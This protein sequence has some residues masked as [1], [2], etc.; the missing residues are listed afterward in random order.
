MNYINGDFCATRPDFSSINPSTE[1]ILGYFPS[2]H[3]WEIEEAIDAAN[4]AFKNWR[5]LS[6][7]QRA[8]YFWRLAKII[9]S[10][11]DYIATNITLET[12][13]TLNE[14]KAEVI[15]ALHM[16]Q[17]CFSQGR[18]A[19]GKTVSSEL[20]ERECS[21]LKKPKGVVVSISPWNFPLNIG[22]MWT[23]GPAL[24]EGNTVIL[25]PSEDAPL[26]GQIIAELYNEAGFPPGV[27]NLIHGNGQI[28]QH[29]VS[30]D[31]VN[32]ICFTGSAEVGQIIRRICA[33]S[34]HKTCSCE[35]GGKSAVV[36]FDDANLELAVDAAIMSA[37]KLSGQRCVSSGRIL[38]QNSV[39]N[40]FCNM[41]VEKSKKIKVGN[42]F[43]SGTFYGP[44]ISK[45]QFEK[46]KNFNFMTNDG[47][48]EILLEGDYNRDGSEGFFITPHVYK[49]KWTNSIYL[50]KEV[51]GPHVALIPFDTV[52]EAI[53][54]YN[55]TDYGLSLSVITNDFK[56]MR[57]M[58]NNCDFGLG[59]V[60]L[61]SIGAESH[62]PFSGVKKSGN[63]NPS[64]AGTFTSVVHEV[65]WSVNYSDTLYMPQG[66]K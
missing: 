61:P 34:W 49:T 64:A 9:E 24:L 50:K 15:E 7:I 12:G 47:Q 46:V 17:Y 65:T 4:Q 16:I 29:L 51:F 53:E 52:E 36:V 60:N 22:G 58:K 33:E 8:E 5:S 1:E 3:P 23:T 19:T 59:Y 14:S 54:I 30:S 63:G 57:E 20:A 62:L 35:L 25:K 31:K 32:H 41:F 38:I 21:V 26:V 43:D 2:S 48:C 27:F 11:I 56:I 18:E 66:L 37:Y 55:D 40:D 44:L 13:K 6:K 28:G 45:I 39:Y 10:K 42:P